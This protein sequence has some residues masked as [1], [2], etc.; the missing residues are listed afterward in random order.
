M[1]RR[2]IRTH[3]NC[4]ALTDP[5]V[6][7]CFLLIEIRFEGAIDGVRHVAQSELAQRHEVLLPKEVTEGSLYP[8]KWVDV[9]APHSVLQ[10]LRGQVSHHNLVY[11]FQN[12]VGHGLAHL[13]SSDALHGG[14][15]AFEVLNI[16]GGEHVDPCVEQ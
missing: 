16:H 11:S 6:F 10:S 1:L 8:F 9:S 3:A 12:P 14:S 13:N 4:N 2:R 15:D 5:E 7:S